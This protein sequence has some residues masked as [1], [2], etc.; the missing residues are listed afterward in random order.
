MN[1]AVEKIESQ[2]LYDRVSDVIVDYG[3]SRPDDFQVH[4]TAILCT[5]LAE[6]SLLTVPG[7][8]VEDV[9]E[10][11]R[12]FLLQCVSAETRYRDRLTQSN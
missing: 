9:R 4:A 8:T 1:E 11:A 7:V 12:G 10:T 5:M 2:E 6:M 3:K